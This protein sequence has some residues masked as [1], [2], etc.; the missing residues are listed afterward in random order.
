MRSLSS[1]TDTSTLR[2]N[3][4][5]LSAASKLFVER[6]THALSESLTS[7]VAETIR[8]SPAPARAAGSTWNDLESM[9]V[10]SVMVFGLPVRIAS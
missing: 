8:P 1:R 5:L 2:L 9:S 7:A 6:P 10:V 4:L 3:E